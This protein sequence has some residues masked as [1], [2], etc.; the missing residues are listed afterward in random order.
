MGVNR[1]GAPTLHRGLLLKNR[2]QGAP[3]STIREVREAGR[4][5][6]LRTSLQSLQFPESLRFACGP[7]DRLAG[8]P[9][10]AT[11]H[12]IARCPRDGS[13]LFPHRSGG[14]S[15]QRGDRFASSC[16]TG[17]GTPRRSKRVD[18]GGPCS[19]VKT[20]VQPLFALYS[21][22]SAGNAAFTDSGAQNLCT[23]RRSA[24]VRL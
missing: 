20:C 18:G 23:F 7:V 12:P 22:G 13:P 8:T 19:G 1:N 16:R 3:T 5:A 24:A 17:Q 10:G 2:L 14:S 4:P 11:E 15:W 21:S 9:S 6:R